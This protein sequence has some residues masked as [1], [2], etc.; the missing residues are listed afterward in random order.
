MRKELLLLPLL[1]ALLTGLPAVAQ[2]PVNDFAG[3]ESQGEIPKDLRLSFDE[4]YSLD[5]KRMRDFTEGSIPNRNRVEAAS[6]M[7][8]RMMSSG[9]ILYG[10]PVTRMIERIADTLLVNHPRL[11]SELRFYTVKSAEVNAFATSQGMVFFNL[12][13]IA[14]ADDES[15]LAF[16]VSHEIIHYYLRHLLTELSTKEKKPKDEEQRLQNFIRYHNRSREMEAEADSLGL[17]LFY[18][19]SPYDREVY[20]RVFDLLQY[21]YLPFDEI[22]FD[23]NQFVSPWFHLTSKCYTDGVTPITAREDYDDRYSTHPNILKRRTA[24]RSV[25]QNA[26]GSQRFV[27]TT[28]EEFAEIRR[29]AQMECVRQDLIQGQYVRAYY[30]AAVLEQRYP[31]SGYPVKA[32]AQALYMLS[33]LRTYNNTNLTT[34]EVIEGEISSYYH[35]FRNIRRDELA[36]VAERRLWSATK[37]LPYDN[38]LRLMTA[39]IMHDIRDKHLMK[40]SFFKAEPDTAVKKTASP[41][42]PQT[43]D[44]YDR[45][46]SQRSLND[47]GDTRRFAFSHFMK[48]DPAFYHV[49]N[50]TTAT[51]SDSTVSPSDSSILVYYPQ[52]YVFNR[53]KE[54]LNYSS[55]ARREK[56]LGKSVA[57]AAK[58]KGLKTIEFSN[59]ELHNHSDAEYYND[60]CTMSEW[61]AE[62]H[63]TDGNFDY[64]GTTYPKVKALAKKYNTSLLDLTRVFNF[65][66]E[67][68]TPFSFYDIIL[69]LIP[70]VTPVKIYQL[71]ANTEVTTT[72]NTLVDVSNM[73]ILN[74]SKT[75]HDYNDSK[76]LV[77]SEIYNDLNS[78]I[79]PQPVN[80]HLGQRFNI[81]AQLGL[82]VPALGYIFGTRA[83]PL[84]LPRPGLNV[85][86]AVSNQW[87][88]TFKGDF[89]KSYNQMPHNEG[90]VPS[91]ALTFN[92]AVRHYTSQIKAP[93]GVYWGVG[94]FY[95]HANLKAPMGEDLASDDDFA[96]F[97]LTFETGRHY[98]FF[99]HLLLDI[100]IRYGLTIAN[101]LKGSSSGTDADAKMMNAHFWTQNFMMPYLGLGWV[102]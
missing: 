15:E 97:G 4:L 3:M 25:L 79:E 28:E 71:P 12:G 61:Y 10:D 23:S 13:L 49:L 66:N 58:A 36:L 72:Y 47:E 16:I 82:S 21:A 42:V 91:F 46:R 5:K 92:F 44:R 7:V 100:G 69:T 74:N 88:I 14:K 98:I 41:T 78:I 20:D 52:Y 75:T 54:T 37:R 24:T 2:R 57:Y 6:Y 102:F 9:Y 50:D 87:A 11:R 45:F 38:T 32:Q 89:S 63:N 51:A 68:K 55:S 94:L 99:N 22:A 29:M 19:N 27:T 1:A 31:Y 93:L 101:P 59:K 77:R 73:H 76:A 48:S 26:R 96:A 40:P 64:Y 85:E 53:N 86:Y 70:P 35:F 67:D 81:T 33:K 65:H 95:S 56:S 84:L 80:G 90:Y 34:P 83:T 30:N 17:I 43:S 60:F 8:H 62:L 18:N 39:D